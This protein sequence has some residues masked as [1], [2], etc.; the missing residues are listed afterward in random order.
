MAKFKAA[1]RNAMPAAQFGQRAKRTFPPAAVAK[2]PAPKMSGKAGKQGAK[3]PVS[4]G[5]AKKL[6]AY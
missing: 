6:A 5:A 4:M 2:A 3:P 1:A